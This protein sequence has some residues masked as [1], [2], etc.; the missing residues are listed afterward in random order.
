MHQNAISHKKSQIFYGEGQHPALSPN[1]R[2]AS[3]MQYNR[4]YSTCSEMCETSE[5]LSAK[6]AEM[7]MR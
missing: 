7:F 2:Q 6:N 1:L 5:K 4:T 3:N